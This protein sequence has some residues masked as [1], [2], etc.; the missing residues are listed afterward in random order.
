VAGVTKFSLAARAVAEKLRVT[1]LPI[2]EFCP[3][4]TAMGRDEFA[5][6]CGVIYMHGVLPWMARR[7]AAAVLTMI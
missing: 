3:A 5:K 7:V 1:R 6:F 4:V 2:E